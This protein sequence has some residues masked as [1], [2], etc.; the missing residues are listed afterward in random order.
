MVLLYKV[1]VTLKFL[2]K[3]LNKKLHSRTMLSKID[4]FNLRDAL[5]HEM[6]INHRIRELARNYIKKD[7]TKKKSILLLNYEKNFNELKKEILK[8]KSQSVAFLIIAKKYVEELNRLKNRIDEKTKLLKIEILIL[9]AVLKIFDNKEFKSIKEHKETLDLT[10]DVLNSTIMKID[11]YEELKWR[12]ES[13]IRIII[14][15]IKEPTEGMLSIIEEQRR[16]LDADNSSLLKETIND[17]VR[18][19]AK[20]II[21]ISKISSMRKKGLTLRRE[22]RRRTLIFDRDFLKILALLDRSERHEIVSKIIID[23]FK[24]IITE[25]KERREKIADEIIK[26][27]NKRNLNKISI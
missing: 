21:G 25:K 8:H 14:N 27:L 26:Q 16:F 17:E 4:D 6:E 22:I 24:K 11:S 19:N 15:N 23:S 9:K 18:N 3:V 13:F 5:E 1:F 10:S 2:V 12:I 7:R 20:L